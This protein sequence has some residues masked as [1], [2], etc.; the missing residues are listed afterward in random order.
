MGLYRWSFEANT[1]FSK[2][3]HDFDAHHKVD[4]AIIILN[5]E[6]NVDYLL[7]IF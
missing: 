1:P 7:K 5:W 6:W 2:I 3:G 4:F